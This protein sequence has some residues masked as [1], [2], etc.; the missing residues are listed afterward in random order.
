MMS[1]AFGPAVHMGGASPQVTVV[2][3]GRTTSGANP[4]A[5]W[6]PTGVSIGTAA[7][8]RLVVIVI[9]TN[10]S[11]ARTFSSATIASGATTNS[12][13][14]VSDDTFNSSVVASRTVASG[15]TAD[16]TVTCNA[17]P[18]TVNID[19]Y[20]LYCDTG[21]TISVKAT[22]SDSNAIST[23]IDF[24]FSGSVLIGGV[25]TPT[26]SGAHTPTGYTN[27]ADGVPIGNPRRSAGKN[28]VPTGSSH[29][30]SVANTG[31]EAVGSWAVFGV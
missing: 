6:S 8:N 5:T 19:C 18:N 3:N 21:E 30:I 4:G 24:S 11:S 22:A 20:S 31:A 14:K 25:Q 12:G 13:L 1:L 26:S 15:T 27:D 28:I 2:Y 9:T 29:A 10:D 17:G 23:T 7:T 16:M